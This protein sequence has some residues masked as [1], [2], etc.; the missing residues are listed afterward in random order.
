MKKI[1]R[2]KMILNATKVLVLF[3]LLLFGQ[4]AKGQ[5]VSVSGAVTGNGSYADLNSAFAAINGGVQT[6]ANITVSILAST[7]E[8]ASAVLNQGLWSSIIISPSGGSYTI[9]GNLSAPIIDLNGAD[10]VTINGLNSGGNALTV[11]NTNTLNLS[12][13]TIRFINDALFNTVTNCTILGSGTGGTLGTITFSTASTI[14]NSNNTISNCNIG[15][16]G[17]NLPNNG[18]FSIGTLGFENRNNNIQNCNVYD[19]FNTTLAPCGVFLSS[20]NS[21]WNISDNRL[22]QTAART[23]TVANTIKAIQINSGNSYTVASNI[24]GYSSAAATGT[25]TMGGTIAT[26]FVGIELSVA[27]LT[28]SSVQNNTITAI[29]LTTSS[30]ASTANGIVCGINA[31]AGR[32]NIVGNLIGGTTGVDLIRGNPS[33]NLGQVIGINSSSTS[34]ITI[35][36]NYIG[37]CS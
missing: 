12:T 34:S 3:M 2:M 35:T 18:I 23:Y 36:G 20:N 33:T 22:Y 19:Y 13:S 6:S 29:T 31:L 37:G 11:A 1:K 25:T 10:L 27:T 5:N 15:A 7:T 8:T 30:G 4:L 32:V 9:T 26:R 16:A 21:H 14:G 24:I 28:A 17:T